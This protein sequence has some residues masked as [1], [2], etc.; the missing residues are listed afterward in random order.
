L[1]EQEDA[2]ENSEEWE[3]VFHPSHLGN[4][5][6]FSSC[7]VGGAPARTDSRQTAVM[8]DCHRKIAIRNSNYPIYIQSTLIKA[9]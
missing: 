8:L 9:S 4:V 1:F 2:V 5:V 7:I 6:S 3:E